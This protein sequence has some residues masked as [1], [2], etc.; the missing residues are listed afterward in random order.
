MPDQRKLLVDDSEASQ[1]LSIA[2]TDL[3][4]LV[5]TQQLSPILIR[6]RRLFQLSQLEELVQL[7]SKVQSRGNNA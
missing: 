7:Y 6:G 3:E 5:S 2:A 1:L 4:W